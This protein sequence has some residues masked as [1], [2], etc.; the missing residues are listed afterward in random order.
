MLAAEESRLANSDPSGKVKVAVALQLPR[1]LV[2]TLRISSCPRSTTSP[3]K[4]VSGNHSGC[5]PNTRVDP[6]STDCTP[7]ELSTTREASAWGNASSVYARSGLSSPER[8]GDTVQS[9]A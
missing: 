6:G 9:L 1:C 4:S 3:A 7:R 2:K 8:D 5:L